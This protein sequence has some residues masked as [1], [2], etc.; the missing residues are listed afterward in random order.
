MTKKPDDWMP[1]DIRRYYGDTTHLTRDEHGGY[2]LL[3]M[4]YWLKGQGLDDNDRQLGQIAKATPGEWKRLRPV[5]APFFTICDGV[6]MQGR[7]ER[8]LGRARVLLESKREAGRAGGLAA[9]GKSGRKRMADELQNNSRTI[10]GEIAKPIADE[11]RENTPSY[12]VPS[13]HTSNKNNTN[14]PR[15]V[16]TSAEGKDFSLKTN[17]V[18]KTGGGAG[19]P[20]YTIKDPASRIAR[21]QQKLAQTLGRNGWIIIADACDTQSPRHEKSLE[22]C[23]EA[24][25]K[26][27]KGWPRNWPTNGHGA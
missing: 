14:L 15:P 4:A 7:A 2:L 16:L 18:G 25:R 12:P 21:F 27:G 5:L 20:H 10:D 24:A 8:E 26:I 13:T 22:L 17:G 23:K 19:E 1:L 3:L 11:W 6:W 9:R